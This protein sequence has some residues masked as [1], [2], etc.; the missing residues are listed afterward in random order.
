MGDSLPLRLFLDFLDVGIHFVLLLCRSQLGHQFAFRSEYHKAYSEY[1]VYACGEDGDGKLLSIA[2]SIEYHFSTFRFAYPVTLHVL[3]RVAPLKAVQTFKKP[4]C[5]GADAK[6]PLLHLFLLDREASAH[7]QTVFDFVI[8]QYRSQALAPVDGRFAEVGD[9]VA[10]QNGI[11]LLFV[12]GVPLLCADAVV[13][14]GG[15]FFDEFV[16]RARLV[17]LRVI[18]AREHLQEGPL[19]PFVK[20]RVA[21]S[22][23]A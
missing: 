5:V 22:Y 16:N 11:F 7:A 4:F 3:K 10:H 9:A 14:G 20:C 23:L 18:P 8:G 15:E 1:G 19:S 21:G 13:A 6:L 17:L 2:D 12:E